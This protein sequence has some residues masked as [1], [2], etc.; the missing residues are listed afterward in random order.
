MRETHVGGSC[1]PGEGTNLVSSK[2]ELFVTDKE[3]SGSCT[4]SS[5]DRPVRDLQR[6]GSKDG[7]KER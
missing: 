6:I 1:K 3:G 7:A 5:K 4:F 2:R